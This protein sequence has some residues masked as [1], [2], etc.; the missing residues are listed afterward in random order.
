M[1]QDFDT[2]TIWVVTC[3][4]EGPSHPLRI[5]RQPQANQLICLQCG[6]DFSREQ[7]LALVRQRDQTER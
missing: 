4:G 1:N 5:P 7:A 6:K 2:E 3:P